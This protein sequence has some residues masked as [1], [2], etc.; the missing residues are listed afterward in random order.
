MNQHFRVLHFVDI[1]GKDPIEEFLD[2]LKISN[3]WGIMTSTISRLENVGLALCGTKSAKVFNIKK[4]LYEL[5]KGE[6]RIVF[7]ADGNTFVL[8]HGFPKYSKKTYREDLRIIEDRLS[9][10]KL[11][12]NK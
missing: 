2:S 6:N 9:K 10:Y 3:Q 12:K 4:Q 7:F 11:E 1:D 5:T 8:L